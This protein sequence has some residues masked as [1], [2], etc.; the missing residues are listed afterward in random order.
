MDYIYHLAAVTSSPEFETPLGERDG[1]N[2][3][4]K[5]NIIAAGET[6]GV[7]KVILASPSS[8][9]GSTSEPSNE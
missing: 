3:L 6:D 9:Y 5:Y 7:K 8:I 1:V 4:G 2:V